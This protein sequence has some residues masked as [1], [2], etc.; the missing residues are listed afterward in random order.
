MNW[1]GSDR[2]WAITIWGALIISW[3]ATAMAATASPGP[4]ELA[5]VQGLA[6]DIAVELKQACP[7][8]DAASQKAFDACRQVLFKDSLFKR[9]LAP[10]VLWGRQASDPTTPLKDS[11]LTQF[12]PEVYAGIY[13]PIF[14]FDGTVDVSWVEREK[15][16]RIK[17]GATFRNRLP[18]GLFPYPFWHDP[19][20]WSAY[21]NANALLLWVSPKAKPEIRV[22]QF[23]WQDGPLA[24]VDVQRVVTP[25]FDGRWLWTDEAGKTQPAVTLFDGLYSERNPHKAELDLR[26]RELA[27]SLREGQC[28]ECHVPSNPQGL[29]RLVL[30]Q[31][32]A[33]AAGEIGRIL[34]TVRSERMPV[35]ELGVESALPSG[36]KQALIKKGEAF[37]STVLAAKRWKSEQAAVSGTPRRP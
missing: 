13:L 26:Y 9:S 31:T 1:L 7:L 32:P 20:K 27:T 34:K 25:K 29:K 23:T 15:L 4:A 14:M 11:R 17:L 28:L 12:A 18:P 37:E 5:A 33:H 24:G 2:W 8:S 30:L 19:A 16:Y 3:A 35:D 22:A 10:H 21:E 36:V 6:R